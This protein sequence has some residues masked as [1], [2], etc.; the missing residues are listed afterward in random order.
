MYSISNAALTCLL[1]LLLSTVAAHAAQLCE[2]ANI[3][4]STPTS[5]FTIHDIG[6]TV[7]DNKTGLMWKRCSEGQ[8]WNGSTCTGIAAIYTWQTALQQVQNI[9]GTGGFAGKKDWRVP[10]IKE[11]ASLVEVQCSSPAINMTV[12]PET[13]W[14]FKFFWSSSSEASISNQAWAVVP[15]GGNVNRGSKDANG[16]VRLVRSGQ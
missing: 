1:T 8:D 9:N 11:L 13:P 2:P 10:N 5:Q 7:T 4:A 12:F 16:W 14:V 15:T 6:T 3:P